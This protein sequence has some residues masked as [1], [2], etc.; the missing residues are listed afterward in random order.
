MDG[1]KLECRPNAMTEE[2]TPL[3][4][5]TGKVVVKAP[6]PEDVVRCHAVIQAFRYDI[7]FLAE[8]VTTL[9]KS[10]LKSLIKTDLTAITD[11]R[12]AT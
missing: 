8:F 7:T 6:F 5:R 1:V 12:P 2:S 11:C 4:S 3:Y 10:Y 9:T